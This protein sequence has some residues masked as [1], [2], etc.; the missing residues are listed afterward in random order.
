MVNVETNKERFNELV[1]SIGIEFDKDALFTFLEN[2][3]FYTAPATSMYSYSY[4]GGLCQHCLDVYDTLKILC[5]LSGEVFEDDTIKLVGLFHDFYKV[6]YYEK[7]VVNKKVYSETGSKKDSGGRFD[8]VSIEGYKVREAP[9]RPLYGDNS[10]TSYMLLSKFIP[11]TDYETVAIINHNCGMD[12]SYS[13]K[14]LS[15]IL[16]SNHLTVLLHSA[17]MICTYGEKPLVMPVVE[18][19]ED[20]TDGELNEELTNQEDE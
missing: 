14:D 18:E 10:F 11:L 17:D 9:N 15:H 12:N 13:N 1:N 6:A 8:W 7:S 19:P 2:N 5:E 3:D 4:E 20:D 16:A